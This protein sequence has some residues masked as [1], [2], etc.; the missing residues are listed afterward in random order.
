MT[1]ELKGFIS[2]QIVTFLAVANQR[3]EYYGKCKLELQSI[4][5]ETDEKLRINKVVNIT[6]RLS[7]TEGEIATYDNIIQTLNDILSQDDP[8]QNKPKTAK[9][10]HFV[11]RNK[12]D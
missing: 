10:I 8:E 4:P 1:D 6:N 2:E 7:Y 11:R 9:I 5:K 3:R 12:D